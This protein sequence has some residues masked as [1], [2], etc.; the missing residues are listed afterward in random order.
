[1]LIYLETKDVKKMAEA[2]GHTNYERRLLARYLPEE[3]LAFFQ[4]R[5]IR[6]FQTSMIVDAMKDS[7]F[8]L[9]ASGFKNIFEL[10]EFLTNHTFKK[11]PLAK[12]EVAT[13]GAVSTEKVLFG[14]DVSV[15]T[16]LVSLQM[17]IRQA[18]GAI[19]ETAR[20]WDHI[21]K[22]LV[23]YIDSESCDREDLRAYLKQARENA[24]PVAMARII[25]ED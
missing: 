23:E 21:G 17:S 10:N 25:Y 12:G 22:R 8:L 15:L 3:I 2:L 13:T 24:D 5:W 1:V 7:D 19:N 6:I 11:N 16:G 4:E 20:Y 9:P 18:K 14:L